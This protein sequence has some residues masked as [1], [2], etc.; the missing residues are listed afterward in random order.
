[1]TND[2]YIH[3]FIEIQK[4]KNLSEEVPSEF[5]NKVF[6]L[7]FDKLTENESRSPHAER[8]LSLT[9]NGKMLRDFMEKKHP[10]TNLDRSFLI[11]Y[12]LDKI[13]GID[14]ITVD[15]VEACYQILGYEIP[16]SLYQ[17]MRDLV[18]RYAYLQ[19]DGGNYRIDEDA[20]EKY[21]RQKFRE[22]DD[23]IINN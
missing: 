16:K 5:K 7:L 12:L 21:F 10:Q 23:A 6:K 4:I 3:Y 13:M 8:I 20:G 11:V 2:N 22:K 9:G 14:K 1:M 15:C 18:T 17:N 19:S